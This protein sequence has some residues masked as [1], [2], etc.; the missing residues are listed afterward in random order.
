MNGIAVALSSYCADAFAGRRAASTAASVQHAVERIVRRERLSAALLCDADDLVQEVL[1]LLWR[2]GRVRQ[3]SFATDGEAASYIVRTTKNR[4]QSLRRAANARPTWQVPIEVHV[5]DPLGEEAERA[6]AFDVN[7]QER[8][9]AWR[10]DSSL[11]ERE[12]SE[13]LRLTLELLT[14]LTPQ[15]AAARR[16]PFNQTI[17]S[18]TPLLV[19]LRLR[20]LTVEDWLRQMYGDALFEDERQLELARTRV[21]AT[22]SRVRAAWREWVRDALAGK[23][24]VPD[25]NYAQLALLLNLV[26]NLNQRDTVDGAEED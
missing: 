9:A 6:A 20:E 15:A 8:Q 23:H 2:A 3:V 4:I 12:R 10:P 21:H 26:E 22:H 14:R 1:L 18:V 5:E 16:A 19:A 25:T 17:Q 7:L 11:L 24:H 13:Q